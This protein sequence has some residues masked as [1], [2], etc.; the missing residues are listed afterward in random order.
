MH[1]VIVFISFSVAFFPRGRSLTSLPKHL[2]TPSPSP[3]SPGTERGTALRC[4][5]SSPHSSLASRHPCLFFF[6]LFSFLFC[7]F[8]RF[9][10]DSI[11]TVE[12]RDIHTHTIFFWLHASAARIMERWAKIESVRKRIINRSVLRQG[13]ERIA[14]QSASH[15]ERPKEVRKKWSDATDRSETNQ[16]NSD[17]VSCCVL[18]GSQYYSW[19]P[20]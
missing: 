3:S 16:E 1:V 18:I 5:A 12:K 4:H 13:N 11:E 15:D 20:G 14:R 19:L 6:F 10:V 9:V 7:P 17:E 8:L 2:S